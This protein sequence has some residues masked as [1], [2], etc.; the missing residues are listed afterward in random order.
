[1]E[2]IIKTSEYIKPDSKEGTYPND[3]ERID[4]SF[5]KKLH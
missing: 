2:N 1:M 5:A 3:N 4:V